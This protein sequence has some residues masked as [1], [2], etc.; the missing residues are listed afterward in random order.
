MKKSNKVSVFY[1]ISAISLLFVLIGGGIYGIYVSV[2]LNFTRTM[3]SNLTDAPAGANNVSYGGTVNYSTNMTGV[4]ILSIALIVLAVLDFICLVK[5]I[6]FFKQF[7]AIR[8][9]NI[10]KKIEKKVKSKGSVIFFAVVI[11]LLSIAAGIAGIF[12]NINSLVNSNVTWMLYAVDAMVS[13][14]ALVSLVL[15]IVKLKNRSKDGEGHGSAKYSLGSQTTSKNND[16]G[17][18]KSFK[19]NIDDMEYK[20]LKLKNLKA[21]KMISAEEYQM[22]H[23]KLIGTLHEGVKEEDKKNN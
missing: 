20:L 2:G 3:V 15:L 11:D 1:I 7:K 19:L 12:V 13:V 5:Q 23:D 10:E 4:I 6:T 18:E 17:I 8:E 16:D 22:L 9:S 21:S 14:F